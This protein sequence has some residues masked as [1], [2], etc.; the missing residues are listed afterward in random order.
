LLLPLTA[1][2]ILQVRAARITV[3]PLSK[4]TTPV[5]LSASGGFVSI[6]RAEKASGSDIFTEGDFEGFMHLDGKEKQIQIG[7]ETLRGDAPLN[8]FAAPR[9]IL[10]TAPGLIVASSD[11]WSRNTRGLARHETTASLNPASAMH[12][13]LTEG[14]LDALKKTNQTGDAP[15]FPIEG[16]ITGLLNFSGVDSV[17]QVSALNMKL[18][19]DPGWLNNLLKIADLP[20]GPVVP[21]GGD[22]VGGWSDP[23][24]SDDGWGSP[25]SS[26]TSSSSSQPPKVSD[27]GWGSSSGSSSNDWGTTGSAGSSDKKNDDW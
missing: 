23:T 15:D 2:K 17:T 25:T 4:A 16:T 6:R 22:A 21:P 27:D 14:A 20:A 9:A 10:A 26:S 3:S 11:I 5:I 13:T 7:G 1:L 19:S 18:S 8:P 12:L 24:P